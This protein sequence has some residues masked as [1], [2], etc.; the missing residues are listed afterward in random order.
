M[1]SFGP[2]IALTILRGMALRL[3]KLKRRALVGRWS[4]EQSPKART[5][6]TMFLDKPTRGDICSRSSSLFLMV[7]A[8]Q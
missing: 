5:L 2:R 4:S 8:I 6:F 3:K 7:G 1:N